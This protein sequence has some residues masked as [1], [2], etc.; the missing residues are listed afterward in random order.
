MVCCLLLVSGGLCGILMHFCADVWGKLRDFRPGVWDVSAARRNAKRRLQSRQS[1]RKL[2]RLRAK[3]RRRSKVSTRRCGCGWDGCCPPSFLKS[4]NKPSQPVLFWRV[5]RNPRR[6]RRKKS[7]IQRRI[8]PQ[9]ILD[10]RR[11]GRGSEYRW[12]CW[13]FSGLDS[14][15]LCW[16]FLDIF[17]PTGLLINPWAE[18]SM[19]FRPSKQIAWCPTCRSMQQWPRCQW[20]Y[21]RK[22][23]KMSSTEKTGLRSVSSLNLFLASHSITVFCCAIQTIV[24]SKNPPSHGKWWK[25]CPKQDP[26]VCGKDGWHEGWRSWKGSRSSGVW[27]KLPWGVDWNRSLLQNATCELHIQTDFFRILVSQSFDIQ[28]LGTVNPKL[29]FA[30]P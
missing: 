4:H 14:I 12:F 15:L 19:V 28:P 24:V 7:L 30:G 8:P 26:S 5:F 11:P 3:Q 18:E 23:E 1:S 9:P 20:S 13:G 29:L 21:F 10:F 25:L 17:G 6:R 16:R 27:W 22:P 2:K